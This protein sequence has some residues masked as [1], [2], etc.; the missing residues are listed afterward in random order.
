MKPVALKYYCDPGHGWVACK[1]SL[2]EQL[3]I[4]PSISNYSY[5]RGGTAYLEEDADAPRLI[6]ALKEA[7]ISYTLE[8]RHTDRRSCI[9]S[10]LRY[11]EV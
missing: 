8:R 10:Y 6:H 4:E 2:I 3:G 11:H 5:R 1:Q 7:G 9:R